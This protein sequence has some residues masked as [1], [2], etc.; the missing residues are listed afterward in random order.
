MA[1]QFLAEHPPVP[2]RE[3]ELMAL[4]LW[5]AGAILLAALVVLSLLLA[6][7]WP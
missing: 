5:G 4:A 7:R 1:R 3:P 6:F 2:R